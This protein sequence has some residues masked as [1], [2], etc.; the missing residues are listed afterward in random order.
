MWGW[1]IPIF[2]KNKPFEKGVGAGKKLEKIMKSDQFQT[3]KLLIGR[4]LHE[5]IDQL[6]DPVTTWFLFTAN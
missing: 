4:Y 2:T 6:W 5:K 3:E 1:D